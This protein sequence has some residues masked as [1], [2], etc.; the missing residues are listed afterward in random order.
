MLCEVRESA[1]ASK[2]GERERVWQ[3]RERTEGRASA[4]A[5]V[6]TEREERELRRRGEGGERGKSRERERETLPGISTLK[7]WVVN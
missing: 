4:K 1:R 3:R 7:L 5:G 2:Q 6:R